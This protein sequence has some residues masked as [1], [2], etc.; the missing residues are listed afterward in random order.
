MKVHLTLAVTIEADD[1][2]EA[3]K[4]L[5]VSSGT[6]TT[7]IVDI[8]V[9]HVEDED[10]NTT[11]AVAITDEERAT[12]TEEQMNTAAHYAAEFRADGES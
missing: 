12:L 5:V 2:N 7:T 8:D 6:N 11:D 3:I 10:G 1:Y 4:E 9:D